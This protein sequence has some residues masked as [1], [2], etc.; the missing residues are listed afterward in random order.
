MADSS[1]VERSPLDHPD[2][3]SWTFAAIP[4]TQRYAAKDPAPFES[5]TT[6]LRDHHERERIAAVLHEGDVVDGPD[7][8]DEQYERADRAIGHLEDAGLPLVLAIGN[9]D[10]DVVAERNAGGFETTFPADR[11]ADRTWWGGSADGTVYN[12]Y[13]EF[14]AGDESWLGFA[15]ELFPRERVLAWADEVIAAHPDHRVAVCTHGYLYN[16]GTPIDTGDRWSK[17]SYGLAGHNGDELWARFLERHPTIELVVSG[18]VLCSGN[19]YRRTCRADGRPVHQLLANYQS[20]DG[21]R[22]YLTLLRWY[23]GAD[24]LTVETYSPHLGQFHPNPNLHFR[25]ENACDPDA[26]GSIGRFANLRG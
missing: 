22:G 9:H 17:V 19:A 20:L 25:I 3:S 10:Y 12:A 15:L 18:H 23:R 5:I 16:D 8:D 26:T 13:V 1:L 11:F 2:G 7:A 4:D 14:D 6:W 21:G 24:V